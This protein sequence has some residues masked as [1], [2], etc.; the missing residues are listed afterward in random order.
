[1]KTWKH[2]HVKK[3]T[4]KVTQPLFGYF[5]EVDALQGVKADIK[6]TEDAL[7]IDRLERAIKI[8]ALFKIKKTM[9]HLLKAEID[10]VPEVER[11]NSLYSVDIVAMAHAHMIYV[12]FKLF[13]AW[14]EDPKIKC[15]GIRKNLQNLL[16]LL[17]LTELTVADS[18]SNY[19]NGYFAPGTHEI[20][21]E[22]SKKLMK[23]LRPQMIP[24][25]EAFE[26]PDEVINSCI[27]NSYGD[28]YET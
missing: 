9:E 10:G 22:A 1:M 5:Y 16:R 14:I 25:I 18:S 23:E 17:A 3:S 26:I 4:T 20:L 15:G 27:G 21:M 2:I 11:V 28:I 8:R 13:R 7:D 19:E 6:S 12:V 24:L